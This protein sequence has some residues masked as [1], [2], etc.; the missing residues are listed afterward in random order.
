MSALRLLEVRASM[1]ARLDIQ[2]TPAR[3][4]GWV[5]SELPL[6]K[7]A[8][9]GRLPPLLPE[10]VRGRWLAEI[11][12]RH[13]FV[14]S[15][16]QFPTIV[17]LEEYEISR[18]VT[19]LVQQHRDSPRDSLWYRDLCA[20]LERQGWVDSHGGRHSSPEE[21]EG[22]LSG[23]M[24]PLI[25][26]IEQHGFD[27]GRTTDTGWALLG[28]NGQVLKTKRA[29]HRFFIARALG[30]PTFPLQV[31]AVHVDWWRRVF[32]GSRRAGHP[33]LGWEDRLE[34]ALARVSAEHSD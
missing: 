4:G 7:K 26:S 13:P 5:W 34:A 14:L 17:P 8:R 25:A 1:G 15:R 27:P 18:W 16:R 21:V 28:A 33:I 22:F 24:L 23:Y 6:A 19:D 32:P 20:T 30:V 11:R 3:V 2:V 29:T 31:A 12:R 9:N 10:R